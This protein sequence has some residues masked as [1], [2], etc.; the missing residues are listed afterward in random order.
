M[1]ESLDS[2]SK[3]PSVTRPTRGR[4]SGRQECLRPDTPRDA[5]HHCSGRLHIRHSLR[6]HDAVR[7]LLCRI[8]HGIAGAPRGDALADLAGQDGAWDARGNGLG[9]WTL[10]AH[11]TYD[12]AE[13][14]LYRG[15]GGRHSA[16]AIGSAISTV[17]G[18]G[19]GIYSGDGG[20][21]TAAELAPRGWRSV[22]TEPT[23]PPR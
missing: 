23:S 15:D 7:L 22:P 9:G 17:A 6:K 16:K 19:I 2:A 3:R 1:S 13:Q 5:T 14:L 8:D 12:P 4:R 11:H 10:S 18:T 21:A 20:L